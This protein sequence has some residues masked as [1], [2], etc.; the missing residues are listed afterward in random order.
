MWEDFCKSI[1]S[2]LKEYLENNIILYG[3]TDGA[4]FLKWF[5]EKFLHKNIKCLLDR[6]ETSQH[7]SIL[8]LMSLYYLYE[9]NDVILNTM[10]STKN[11]QDEFEDIGELWSNVKYSDSQVV[12][13]LDKLYSDSEFKVNTLNITFYDWLEYING[14]DIISTVRRNQ[15]KGVGAHGYYPTDFRII[16]EAFVGSGL[17][18]KED[19]ILDF[20][21]G[22][23]ASL[24]ALYSCGYRKL[25]GIEYTEN[26]YDTLISNMEKLNINYSKLSVGNESECDCFNDASVCCMFGN[27]AA[28]TKHLDEY[29]VFF[30]FNP[31]S[32][33]L[34]KIVFQ[35]IIDS[36]V[37]LPRQVKICYSEPICHSFLLKSGHFRK[38]AD[39]GFNDSIKGLTYFTNV[40]ES[41]K[42]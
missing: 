36:L 28:L 30:F 32:Y 11:L 42:G 1:N 7:A 17:F 19:K 33:E 10:P 35:N 3:S 38:I 39:F 8:H 20:G 25:G 41:I 6:W 29:N 14:I 13:I 12:N 24:I 23:G 21:C 2:I 31:F 26:I 18:S 27:A 9:E 15:V 34:S 40:Y 16:Y 37:R 4:E 5:F 22:K